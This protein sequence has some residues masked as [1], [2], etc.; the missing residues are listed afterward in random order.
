[1]CLYESRKSPEGRARH[2]NVS[3]CYGSGHKQESRPLWARNPPKS[4]KKVFPGLPARSVKKVSKRS[5]MSRK[6]VKK[7]TK[8]VFGDFLDTFLTLRAGRPGSPF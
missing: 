7:T 2:L 8:S 4:L 3:R 1:M 5:Q 6:K